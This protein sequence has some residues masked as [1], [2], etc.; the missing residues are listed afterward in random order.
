MHSFGRSLSGMR[1]APAEMVGPEWG[2]PLIDL[3]FGLPERMADLL[4]M[5]FGAGSTPPGC[6]GISLTPMSS[7]WL[8][9][10]A[11]DAGKHGEP[12]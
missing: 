10:C 12:I 8:Q 9:Q 11:A 4:V 5:L 3:T 2:Q 7:D 6:N 1:P